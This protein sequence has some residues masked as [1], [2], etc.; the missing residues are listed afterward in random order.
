MIELLIVIAI[1][2]IIAGTVFVALDPLK[3][4]KEARDSRRWGDVNAILS[5][6]K[7]SQVDNRGLYIPSIEAMALSG[8]QVIG[9]ANAGCTCGVWGVLPC[10]NLTALVDGGYLASVPIDP[11]GGTAASTGYYLVKMT[12]GTV[13]VGAC[14]PE[15]ANAK[16]E[17]LR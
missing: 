9:T 1:I 11:K 13:R 10:V 7:I 17:V 3:R 15:M 4:F 2:A 16:I 12:N 8:G 5:A 14:A 6:I